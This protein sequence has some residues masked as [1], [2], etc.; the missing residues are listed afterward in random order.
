[1]SKRNR[2]SD[3]DSVSNKRIHIEYD[4]DMDVEE[5]KQS[6]VEEQSDIEEIEMEQKD[7]ELEDRH[8]VHRTVKYLMVQRGSCCKKNSYRVSIRRKNAKIRSI[9]PWGGRLQT[10]YNR[11]TKNPV[12]SMQIFREICIEEGYRQIGRDMFIIPDR[13]EAREIARL[14]RVRARK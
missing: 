5:Q 6:D 10:I 12:R 3:D 4:D 13:H 1:M 2:E 9:S 8:V 14:A 7:P 11:K